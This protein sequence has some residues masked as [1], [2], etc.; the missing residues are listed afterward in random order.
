MAD[1]LI[2][3]KQKL[4]DLRTSVGSNLVHKYN[5]IILSNSFSPP[6]VFMDLLLS[7]LGR[8]HA[9]QEYYLED[10]IQ[11]VVPGVGILPVPLYLKYCVH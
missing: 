4:L 8:Q 7:F 11:V 10:C 9:V 3:W 6:T 1:F 5:C 2:N